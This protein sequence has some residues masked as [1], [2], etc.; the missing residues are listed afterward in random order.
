LEPSKNQRGKFIKL[1]PKKT[2]LLTLNFQ[3]GIVGSVPGAEAC[4]PNAA[5][6]VEVARKNQYLIIHVG[7]GF[8]TG[9]PEIGD[10]KSSFQRVKQNGL[11]VKGTESSEF[12]E[13]L[14]RPEDLIIYKQRVSA[15]CENNLRMTLRANGIENLILFGISTSGIVL[16]TLRQAA[17]MDFQCWVIKDAYFDRDEEVHRVLTEKVFPMQATVIT[18]NEFVAE[19]AD[20]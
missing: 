11:F 9:H 10:A 4:V 13:S 8:F 2:A 18:T 3:N 6:A 1:D 14:V 12:H 15:F 16:S 20:A 17:D 7:L 5:K 19:G